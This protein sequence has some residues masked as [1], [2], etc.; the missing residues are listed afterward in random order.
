MYAGFSLVNRSRKVEGRA[1]EVDRGV[2]YYDSSSTDSGTDGI[3]P[4]MRGT[5][6]SPPFFRHAGA[7]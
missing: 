7:T 5:L 4:T 2:K 6:F 1:R 3:F